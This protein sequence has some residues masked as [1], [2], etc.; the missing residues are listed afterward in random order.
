MLDSRKDPQE[1]LIKSTCSVC[2]GFN[3]ETLGNLA[4]MNRDLPVP[5]NAEITKQL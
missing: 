5:T 2:M 4:N 3:L 1:L